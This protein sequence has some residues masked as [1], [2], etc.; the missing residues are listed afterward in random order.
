MEK[1]VAGAQTKKNATK[2]EL[3]QKGPHVFGQ[4]G[5]EGGFATGKSDRWEGS[6]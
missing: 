1:G 6:Q 4:K 5:R 3:C 2:N